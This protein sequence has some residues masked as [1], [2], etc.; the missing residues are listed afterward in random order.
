VGG[1][2][3]SFAGSSLAA[4]VAHFRQLSANEFPGAVVIRRFRRDNRQAL[5]F[6]LTAVLCF[7]AEQKVLEGILTNVNKAHLAEEAGRRITMAIFIDT[8]LDGD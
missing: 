4:S 2:D 8:L 1:A 3:V 7:L 6:C 5:R